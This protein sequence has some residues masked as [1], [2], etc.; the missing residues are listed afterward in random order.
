MKNKAIAVVSA[1]C[2]A[3]ADVSSV[4]VY[5]KA[6]AVIWEDM[7]TLKSVTI[8][9]SELHINE[10]AQISVEWND[11]YEDKSYVEYSSSRTTVAMVDNSGKVTANGC[12]TAVITVSANGEEFTVTVNVKPVE[13]SGTFGDGMSWS[14]DEETSTLTVSGEGE[15]EL[16]DN[17]PWFDWH[18]FIK[19][20]VISEGITNI[21]EDMFPICTKLETVELPST[22]VSIDPLAFLISISLSE[23]NVS[24]ENPA[25]TSLD[26]V[27]FSKDMTEL[28]KY[29]INKADEEY[30]VP[31]GVEKLGTIAFALCK[32][33]RSAVIPDSVTRIEENFTD[34]KSL[35]AVRMSEGLEYINGRSLQN[36]P[37]IA[38]QR[39]SDPI[40]VFNGILFDGKAFAGEY[41]ISDDITSL[42]DFA[43]MHDEELTSVV[44]PRNMDEISV[45]AFDSCTSLKNVT[46]SEDL[47]SIGAYAFSDTALT[48]VVVPRT[49]EN[50]DI[51][52]FDYCPDLMSV[53]ILA[54]ECTIYDDKTTICNSSSMNSATVYSGVIRGY[55]GSTA[56]KYAEKYGYSFEEI[57]SIKGDVN[58]DGEVT[59][60][61]L[62]ALGNYVLGDRRA[63]V[64]GCENGDI[65]S[66][67]RIS[68]LDVCM[69]RK[70]LTE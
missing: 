30:A 25:Y 37:W 14:F 41:T 46:F 36:T 12:G 3:A 2:L 1:L 67:G 20:A 22:V 65:S 47:R 9:S 51:G 55:K 40:I 69:L 35:E 54:P 4:P 7:D 49:V 58:L 21:P 18:S 10:T 24:P 6:S 17:A 19:K 63:A 34:C 52:A 50:I 26:G 31:D 38:A 5:P 68:S 29:P 23:I 43:F 62:V 56:E 42:A 44:M 15:L 16:G 53:T 11:N 64:Y 28:V 45:C 60:A 57:T 13:N 33:L 48:N 59:A 27:L 8:D 32:N 70:L 66:D 61:D 39:E